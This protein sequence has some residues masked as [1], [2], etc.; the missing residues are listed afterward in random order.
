M[1]D[2]YDHP[3][4]SSLF[5]FL[6]LSFLVSL[7]VA[8]MSEAIA[9]STGDVMPASGAEAEAGQKFDIEKECKLEDDIACKVAICCV[10]WLVCS[11][12]RRHC[13]LW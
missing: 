8:S 9:R 13:W 5:F 7:Q 11:T 4:V 10:V 3:T 1:F 12:H 2:R 6:F